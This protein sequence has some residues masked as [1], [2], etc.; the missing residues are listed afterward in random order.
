MES[1]DVRNVR[2]QIIEAQGYITS[3]QEEQLD[4][5]DGMLARG[6]L[7]G[8]TLEAVVTRAATGKVE[9]HGI[10]AGRHKNPLKHILLQIKI[11]IQ[12]YKTWRRYSQT[13]VEQ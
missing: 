9:D 8:F 6:E 11:R 10:I 1:Q 4:R 5:I 3:E 2:D 13:P 12:R 7:K